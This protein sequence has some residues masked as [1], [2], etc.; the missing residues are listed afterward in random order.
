MSRTG[1]RAPDQ[2]G[3]FYVPV[4]EEDARTER[5][6]RVTEEIRTQTEFVIV[7]AHWGSNWGYSPPREHVPLAHRLIDAGADVIFGH[8]AHVCRGIEIYHERPI[9][10]ST[11]D[12]IDD[13]A[14]DPVERNDRSFLFI[15][16]IEDGRFTRVKLVPTVIQDFPGAFGRRDRGQGK[17]NQNGTA[18]RCTR[19]SHIVGRIRTVPD[20]RDS[21]TAADETRSSGYRAESCRERVQSFLR[22]TAPFREVECEPVLQQSAGND[23]PALENQLGL[24]AE[25]ERAD[26]QHPG[27]RWKPEADPPNLT[28]CTHE[29]GVREQVE[30][31]RFT[32]PSISGCSISHFT[33][34]TKSN[35]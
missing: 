23:S 30:Y 27:C 2:G 14:I 18:L 6:L 5:L 28:Q 24:R 9:L 19:D 16:E 32:T 1:R 7:A 12:F 29:V 13:Y 33:A 8:S 17:R 35:S 10:Y 11:G 20:V 26:F 4:E 31:A 34:R 25:E 21:R 22:G 3:V 15:L